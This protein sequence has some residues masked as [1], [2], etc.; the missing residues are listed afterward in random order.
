MRLLNWNIE[1]MNNWFVGGSQVSF[2]Q[3]APSH[4]I[5]DVHDLAG[6]V[7]QVINTIDPDVLTIQEGPSDRMGSGQVNQMK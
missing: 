6:R 5:T 2:R 1:W 3:S 7:A 4:G